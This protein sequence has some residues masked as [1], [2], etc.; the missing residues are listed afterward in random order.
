[1]EAGDSIHDFLK[2]IPSFGLDKVLAFLEDS[3]A[4][5]IREVTHA[6]AAR[7]VRSETDFDF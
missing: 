1:L 6:G 2:D 3:S 5:I 7:R 4:L